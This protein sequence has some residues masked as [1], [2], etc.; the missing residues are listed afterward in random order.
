MADA[1]ARDLRV[2][3]AGRS[4]LELGAVVVVDGGEGGLDCNGR[5][6]PPVVITGD[7]ERGARDRK[8]QRNF[9]SV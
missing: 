8:G 4:L 2:R 9:G 5:V 3:E 1:N 7:G 6:G